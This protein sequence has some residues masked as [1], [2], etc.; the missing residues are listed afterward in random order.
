VRLTALR[1]ATLLI[2][3]GGL[4]LLVDPMLGEP[5]SAPPVESTAPLLRN[6]L[7]ELPVPAAGVV[8]A[9]GV[10]LVSHLHRDHFDEAAGSLIDPDVPLLCQPEDRN[11]LMS[12]GFAQVTPLEPAHEIDGVTVTRVA[13]RH[14][15][16]S[17]EEA[18]GPCSGF[19]LAAPGEP[20]LHVAGDCV[21]C[22][23]LAAVITEH[24]PELIVVNAGAARFL[25]GSPI[26]MTTEDVI[27]TARHA[28]AATVAAVHLEALNHCPM[29]RN[30]LRR[31]LVAAG[32]DQRVRVPEDG[33]LIT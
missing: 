11:T 10:V 30:E 21:W 13:A 9:A 27:A 33:E 2:E 31:H 24:R 16:G 18:L 19:V 12:R 7:V 3:F 8:A 14:T 4:T 23:E 25:D 32:L 28:P 1:N 20:T 17:H 6:P 29:T 22:P 26:S 15:L 5:H